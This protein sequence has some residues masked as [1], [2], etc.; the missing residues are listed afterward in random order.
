MT[1][2]ATRRIGEHPANFAALHEQVIR[3]EVDMARLANFESRHN[4]FA[5][6]DWTVFLVKAGS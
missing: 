6:L 5:D 1:E 3:G 4:I 2:Y